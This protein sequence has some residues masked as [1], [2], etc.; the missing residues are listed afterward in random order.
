M[1]SENEH[2]SHLSTSEIRSLYIKCYIDSAVY[3]LHFTL[4]SKPGLM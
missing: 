4:L 2:F 1:F 3:F